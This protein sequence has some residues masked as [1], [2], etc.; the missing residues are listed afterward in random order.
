MQNTLQSS[1]GRY[2]EVQEDLTDPVIASAHAEA[3]IEEDE[4]AAAGLQM[5]EIDDDLYA[6]GYEPIITR[7]SPETGEPTEFYGSGIN[8]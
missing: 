4:L 6:S 1:D 5:G 3:L 7:V 8:S 2:D